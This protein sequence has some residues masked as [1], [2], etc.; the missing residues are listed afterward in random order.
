[1]VLRIEAAE[2]APRKNGAPACPEGRRL[3]NAPGASS[4]M[5]VAMVI[6][7]DSPGIRG[8]PYLDAR[9]G[10]RPATAGR[11]PLLPSHPKIPGWRRLVAGGGDAAW[12]R[13]WS[14]P[15]HPG[16]L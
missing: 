13:G 9:K 8:F 16:A 15:R 4:R 6:P 12:R 10:E 1:M 11:M 2:T 7:L 14:T 5:C 3:V